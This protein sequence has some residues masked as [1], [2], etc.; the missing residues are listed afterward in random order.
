MWTVLISWVLGTCVTFYLVHFFDFNEKTVII[1]VLWWR[2]FENRSLCEFW[3]LKKIIV[4]EKEGKGLT[5]FNSFCFRNQGIEDIFSGNP[6]KRTVLGC[7]ILPFLFLKSGNRGYIL[8]E[9]EKFQLYSVY[10]RDSG[11]DKNIF[12]VSGN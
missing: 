2:N 6:E 12:Q 4:N 8:R 5:V 3:M 1:V 10:L 7:G 9:F 11:I